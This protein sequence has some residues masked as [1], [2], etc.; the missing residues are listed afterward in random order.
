MSQAT[1]K[2][3]N[4]ICEGGPLHDTEFTYTGSN[5][6]HSYSNGYYLKTN[7]INEDDLVIWIWKPQPK[8]K[9]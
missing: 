6:Y 8:T 7:R 4:A 1:E 3:E 2:T 5:L 9:N